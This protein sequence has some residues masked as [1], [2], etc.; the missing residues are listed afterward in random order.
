MRH[1]SMYRLKAE[2]RT[3]EVVEK[4]VAAL[5]ALPAK[6]P[7]ITASEIGSKP[8][9]M[10]VSSPD[11]LVDFYDIVQII[12]FATPADCM[13]YPLTEG[14]NEFVALS[15]DYIET[16]IGIDYPVNA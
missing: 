8:Y 6:V 13:G 3:P 16:A 14:H 9:E 11:G 10:P 2:Y 12:T 4:L 5:N 7:T 15:H 1:I